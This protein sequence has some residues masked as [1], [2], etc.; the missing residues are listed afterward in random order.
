MTTEAW[1]K[2]KKSGA[3][4]SRKKSPLDRRFTAYASQDSLKVIMV[5]EAH[6]SVNPT[7]P[8]SYAEFFVIEGANRCLLSKRTA[9]DLK[10]LKVGLDVQNVDIKWDPFPKF[11]DV[12]VGC[13]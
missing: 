4:L 5:F 2:L 12:Q 3:K 10:L 1:A 11:P 13:H 6:I 8:S 9:E 7:K